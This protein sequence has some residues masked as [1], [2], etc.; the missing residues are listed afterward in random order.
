MPKHIVALVN[1]PAVYD[2]RVIKQAETLAEAGYRVTV[3]CRRAPGIPDQERVNGVDYV[4]VASSNVR[5]VWMP[6]LRAR[7]FGSPYWSIY[8]RAAAL[9]ALLSPYL[10]SLFLVSLGVR[11]ARKVVRLTLRRGGFG[12]GFERRLGTAA[13]AHSALMLKVAYPLVLAQDFMLPA[14]PVVSEL[15]PDVVHAHDLDTLETAVET[16]LRTGA[17]AVYD[18]HELETDRND[19]RGVFLQY[20]VRLHERCGIAH[21][22]GVVTVSPGIADELVRRYAI[23]RPTVLLNSPKIESMKSPDRAGTR[24]TIRRAL[25]LSDETPLV[26][27][28]GLVT[29]DRCLD[30]MVRALAL[31]PTF[32]LAMV[33]PRNQEMTALLQELASRL[34]VATRLHMVDPLAADQVSDFVRPADLGVITA[35]SLCLSYEHSLPNKLFEMSLAGLPLVVA[36]LA[37]MRDFVQ[38]NRIGVAAPSDQPERLAA[39]WQHVYQERALYRPDDAR[40]ALL[41]DKFG[42]ATQGRQ[43]VSLY[44]GLA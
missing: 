26:V 20:F 29:F 12:D 23:Q 9:L 38:E 28:V 13:A 16:S 6:L 10:A 33:G 41:R 14:L 36:E 24:A 5:H 35:V 30:S 7:Q 39:A 37:S 15:R 11:A 8:A 2:T 22:A 25:G 40:L 32:H 43:L 44:A 34:G 27:Y 19:R 17:R 1:N 21:C 42:W 3:V 18:S 4:R 31:L